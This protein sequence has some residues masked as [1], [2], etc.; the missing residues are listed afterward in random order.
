MRTKR[1]QAGMVA[2]TANRL[3]MAHRLGMRT[4]VG[5]QLAHMGL[6]TWRTIRPRSISASSRVARNL[7]ESLNLR[8]TEN[9]RMRM[10][11]VLTV[12]VTRSRRL[13][14]AGIKCTVISVECGCNWAVR[15]WS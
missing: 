9:L 4:A 7:W 12:A 1:T 15:A 6:L 13:M 2:V 11:A 8:L 5:M 14:V 10:E 3:D